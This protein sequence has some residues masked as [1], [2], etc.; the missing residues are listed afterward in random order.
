M[1]EYSQKMER[2]RIVRIGVADESVKALGVGQTPGAMM[3]NRSGERLFGTA[4]DIHGRYP[5]NECGPGLNCKTDNVRGQGQSHRGFRRPRPVDR[6]ATRA[7][8]GTP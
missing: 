5:G 7:S 6:R 2:A 8:T 1:G 4:P 3:R